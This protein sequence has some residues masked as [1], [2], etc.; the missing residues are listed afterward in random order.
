MQELVKYMSSARG[1]EGLVR[2]GEPIRPGIVPGVRPGA[3]VAA[4]GVVG[5][6]A[7]ETPGAVIEPVPA[8]VRVPSVPAQEASPA[9]VN[10]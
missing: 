2:V 10:P 4:P 9:A 3:P 1:D 6:P 5:E 7:V 8:G